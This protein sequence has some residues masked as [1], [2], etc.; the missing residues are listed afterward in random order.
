[1]PGWCG[2]AKT[3]QRQ[4]SRRG[5]GEWAETST[6]TSSGAELHFRKG[7]TGSPVVAGEGDSGLLSHKGGTG[8]RLLC[9]RWLREIECVCRR[10]MGDLA[11][12]LG[13]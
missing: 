11:V 10:S 9:D 12:E 13:E 2:K 3:Y 6:G 4:D 1:M 7:G 8:L 5:P